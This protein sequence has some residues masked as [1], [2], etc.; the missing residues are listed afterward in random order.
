MKLKILS[1]GVEF[2]TEEMKNKEL[3]ISEIE[4]LAVNFEE[5]TIGFRTHPESYVVLK[6]NGIKIVYGVTCSSENDAKYI[7]DYFKN[8]GMKRDSRFSLNIAK[9]IYIHRD[10]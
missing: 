9:G 10:N 8:K 2:K 7:F 3:I 1:I 4:K 5:Y 6:A